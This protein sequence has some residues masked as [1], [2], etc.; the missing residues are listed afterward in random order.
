VSE[1]LPGSAEPAVGFLS[2]RDP[3]VEATVAAIEKSQVR[4]G[5]VLRYIEAGGAALG[6]SADEGKRGIL[7]GASTGSWLFGW[8]SA[9]S[10]TGD[11]K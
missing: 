6:P 11:L 7:T 8:C 9:C 2:P 3:R 10:A 4:E 5:L 1:I